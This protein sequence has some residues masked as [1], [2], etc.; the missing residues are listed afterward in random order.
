MNPIVENY[1]A[2][3]QRLDAAALEANRDPAEIEL[4]AVS[5]TFP[6]EA[7]QT[8]YEFGVRAFG[9]SRIPELEA[10][11]MVL[12]D[13]ITWHFIGQLQANKARKAIK[14]AG[15]IHSVD[16]EALL[17]RLDRI[18]GEE[19]KKPRILLEVNVS[20]EQSKTGFPLSLVEN[21]ARRALRCENLDFA[22]FMTMAPAEAEPIKI[23]AIFEALSLS[24]DELERKLECKLPILSMGMS[25]DF[26]IAAR[27]GSTLV[28]VGT[29]IFGV[30]P[31]MVR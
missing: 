30:R 19:G 22:G 2:V 1:R 25:G 28:R 26:E 5:K 9:E 27:H 17:E 24:R 29:Q 3:R 8:L 21:A 6:I 11:K 18:A 13:D 31:K 20:G 10:K 12:P 16:S 15:V 14:L 4:L 7:I 23:A